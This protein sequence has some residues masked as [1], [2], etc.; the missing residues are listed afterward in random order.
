MADVDGNREGQ[1][2]LIR[3]AL[4]RHVQKESLRRAA[5]EVGMSPTGLSNFLHGST[6]Q[7]PTLR[8][9][10]AWHMAHAVEPD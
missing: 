10:V 9:L 5:R 1:I 7:R 3:A 6:P 4:W 8:K 2:E